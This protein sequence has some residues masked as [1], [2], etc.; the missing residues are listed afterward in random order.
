VGGCV[1]VEAGVS[2]HTREKF[3]FPRTMFFF[4]F[5]RGL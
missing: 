3:Y 5:H 4:Y 2:T 1:E